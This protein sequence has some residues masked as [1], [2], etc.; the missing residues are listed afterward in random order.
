TGKESRRFGG[1]TDAI[2]FSTIAFSSD[3][4]Y[5]AA[6]GKP[7]ADMDKAFVRIVIW[8]ARK[9]DKL[10]E[11]DHAGIQIRNLVFL[12]D[13]QTLVSQIG[14]R[15]AAWNVVSGEAVKK[16]A[17]TVGS[18]FALD[19]K[20]KILATTLGPKVVEFET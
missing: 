13:N 9:G 6:A 3:G 12:P 18:S 4:K 17:H 8:D 5:L 14:S 7:R 1:L 16:I 11:I 19:A 10:K 15:L 2:D 20:G